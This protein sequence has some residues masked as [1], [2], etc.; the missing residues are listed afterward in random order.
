MLRRLPVDIWLTPHGVEYGRFR[1]FEASLKAED[2]IAPFID[3][4]G[5]RASIDRAESTFRTL[6]AGQQQ[7]QRR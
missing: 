1:K 6:L 2:P 3:P 7:A 4:E 5:Y